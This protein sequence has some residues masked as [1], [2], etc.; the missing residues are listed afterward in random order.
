MYGIGDA[1]VY[2][3]TALQSPTPQL[4][5][6]K[7]IVCLPNVKVAMV[8]TIL[9]MAA[10]MGKA[11]CWWCWYCCILIVLVVACKLM[12]PMSLSRHLHCFVDYELILIQFFCSLNLLLILIKPC[13]LQ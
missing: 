4:S 13:L 1:E 3:V 7:A 10:G 6:W 8:R 12:P 5:E 11:N 9:M 2:V